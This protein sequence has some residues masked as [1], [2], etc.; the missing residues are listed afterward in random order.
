MSMYWQMWALFI[1]VWFALRL[2]DIKWPPHNPS[3]NAALALMSALTWYA[4]AH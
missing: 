3:F 2:I 4:S 1:A